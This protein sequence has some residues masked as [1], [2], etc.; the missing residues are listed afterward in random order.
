M[1]NPHIRLA[2]GNE[3]GIVSGTPRLPMWDSIKPSCNSDQKIDPSQKP[4]END[5]LRHFVNFDIN[6]PIQ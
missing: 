3:T 1:I 6:L 5:P 2:K 4:A